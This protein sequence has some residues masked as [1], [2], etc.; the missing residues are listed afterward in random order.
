MYDGASAAAEAVLMA[1]RMLPKRQ[2]VAALAR[3]VARLSRDDSHLLERAAT[4]LEIVEVPFD[5]RDRRDRPS[6]AASGSPTIACSARSPAIP[7]C[8]A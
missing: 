3:A 4:E 2:V 1:R 7:T 6:R 8:S 5:R